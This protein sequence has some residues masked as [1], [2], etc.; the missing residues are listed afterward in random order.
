MSPRGPEACF[1]YLPRACPL[2]A[3]ADRPARDRFSAH[4]RLF[5]SCLLALKA[6]SWW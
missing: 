3:Q 6:G 1:L 5:R 4:Q 2:A